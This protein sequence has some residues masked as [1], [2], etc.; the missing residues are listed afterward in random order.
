MKIM[1]ISK[2]AWPYVV[3]YKFEII[4]FF[5]LYVMW[6]WVYPAVQEH[7]RPGFIAG[8]VLLLLVQGLP[9]SVYV[10]Y[11]VR[12]A[13]KNKEAGNDAQLF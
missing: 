3:T 12:R 8:Y 7:F 13:K 10:W 9:G 2:R 5:T 6:G 1:E 4:L 11:S